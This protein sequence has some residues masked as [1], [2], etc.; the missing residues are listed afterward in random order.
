MKI[1]LLSEDALRLEAAPGPFTI[2]APSAGEAYN[3]F[4]MLASGLATCTLAV[5]H[6]WASHS[7]VNA[8]DL[9]IEV[10]W[11]FAERPHRIGTIDLALRWPALP[12]SRR[13]GAERAATLC[14]IHATLSHAP[15]IS[16]E[17]VS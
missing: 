1:T 7:G 2:E 15:T 12:E 9:V 16:I 14:P 3:P 6:S 10:R 5:L 8:D 17:V 13:V 11:M 4:H